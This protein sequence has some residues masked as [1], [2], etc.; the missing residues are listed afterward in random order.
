M[1][2]L[3]RWAFAVIGAIV[4]VAFNPRRSRRNRWIYWLVP[5]AASFLVAVAATRNAV[6]ALVYAGFTLTLMGFIYL[7]F[8]FGSQQTTART[9]RRADDDRHK[10]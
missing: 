10:R 6:D 2:G 1:D 9:V 4:A 8:F 5:P 3:W 7:K